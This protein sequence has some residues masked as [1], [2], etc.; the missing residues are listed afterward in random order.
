MAESYLSTTE[1][2]KETGHSRATA[3]RI[4]RDNPGFGIKLGKTYRV[5]MSHIERVKR[6]DSS[7]QIAAEVISGGRQAA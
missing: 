3:W 1:M 7:V 4:C 5:P 2:S 6:G